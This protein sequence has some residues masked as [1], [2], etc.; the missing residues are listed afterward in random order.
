MV[1]IKKMKKFRLSFAP[2][3][4]N[5]IAVKGCV[6][7]REAMNMSQLVQEEYEVPNPLEWQLENIEEL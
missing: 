2:T 7:V 5:S 3:L 6:M 1:K 4:R